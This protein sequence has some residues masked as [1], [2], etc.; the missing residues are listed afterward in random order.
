MPQEHPQGDYCDRWPSSQLPSSCT[1]FVKTVYFI[2]EPKPN[3]VETNRV[4]T[5]QG[6]TKHYTLLQ[7]SVRLQESTDS[8]SWE[9]SWNLTTLEGCSKKIIGC[10]HCAQKPIMDYV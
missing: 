5:R 8:S 1:D 6:T 10:H 4:L 9:I 7:N 3:P 2:T